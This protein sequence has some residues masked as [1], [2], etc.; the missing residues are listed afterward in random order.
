MLLKVVNLHCRHLRIGKENKKENK[1]SKAL[2]IVNDLREEVEMDDDQVIQE[3]IDTFPDAEEEIRESFKSGE[4]R[5]GSFGSA[6][7]FTADGTEYNWIVSEDEAERIALEIVKNDLESE[8][9]IFNQDWLQGFM[10]ITPTNKRVIS[11]EEADNRVEGMFDKEI[12]SEADMEDEYEEAEEDD[13]DQVI[14][15]ARDSL[16][17]KYSDEVEDVLDDPIQYFVHDQ[18]IYSVEDLMKQSWITIDTDEAAQDAVNTDG[19]DHFLSHYDGNYDTTKNGIIY[20]RE[21]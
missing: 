17:S 8:P 20:F 9:E 6:G 21:S 10:F 13:K 15:N 1:M 7:E 4:G 2:N 14:E 5:Y 12:L 3:L 19:W 16:R 18:G 11:N